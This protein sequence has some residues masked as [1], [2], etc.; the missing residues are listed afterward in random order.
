MNTYVTWDQ[1]R[2]KSEWL[3]SQQTYGFAYH[4]SRKVVVTTI[5]ILCMITP[6][7]NWII[8]IAVKKIKRGITIRW[9]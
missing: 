5:S 6:G 9:N 4:I 8:P 3:E 2:K 1:F 7:T